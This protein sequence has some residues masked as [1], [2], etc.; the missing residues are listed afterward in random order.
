VRLLLLHPPLLSAVVWRR[1]APLLERAGHQVAVPDLRLPPGHPG[2]WWQRAATAAV[3]AAP[4]ADAVLA[5]SGAGALAPVVLDRSPAARAV[6]L[7][8]AQLAPAAGATAPPPQARA[9]ARELA[10][11]GV[12]PPWTSWWGP[13]EL[14]ALVPDPADRAD[15][16]AQAPRLPQAF[17]DVAVPAPP[18]WE[19][20]QRAYLQLSDGYA[21]A[22]G[23][24]A[25]RGWRVAALPGRHL[26][27]LSRPR[28]VGDAVQELLTAGA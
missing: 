2:D 18:G 20:P 8:D 16:S 6:V 10:V 1:L 22:A 26:D 9:A 13:E 11:D 12:L 7:I 14:A 15:L 4:D 27:L 5:H 25:A 3:A 28:Q 21:G 24:A 17:Y 19:P 23:Q